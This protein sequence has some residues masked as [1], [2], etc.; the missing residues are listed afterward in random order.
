[1]LRKHMDPFTLIY[2]AAVC[3]CLGFLAPRLG[4]GSVRFVVGAIV[5]IAA[6]AVLPVVRG[7]V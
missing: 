3:A 4:K 5:G 2:Y 6:A 1:M 7:M